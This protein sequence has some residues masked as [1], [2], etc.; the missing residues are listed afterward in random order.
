MADKKPIMLA[1]IPEESMPSSG[2]ALQDVADAIGEYTRV[3]QECL[4]DTTPMYE[5]TKGTWPGGAVMRTVPRPAPGELPHDTVVAAI[6]KDP[7]AG[8]GDGNR[9]ETLLDE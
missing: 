8:L 3:V 1:G 2:C 7:G 5:V 9:S 6:H 4:E